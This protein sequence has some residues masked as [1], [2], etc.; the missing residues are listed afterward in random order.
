LET[1]FSLNEQNFADQSVFVRKPYRKDIFRKFIERFGVDMISIEIDGIVSAVAYA[2]IYKDT[3][4]GMNLGVNREIN[5][6]GKYLHCTQI[7]RAIALGAATYDVGKSKGDSWKQDFK[8][9]ARPQYR[10][11]V[12]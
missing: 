6:L 4:I 3:Y 10:L 5:N 12:P 7:E 11:I 1:L 8:F 2:L 9:E